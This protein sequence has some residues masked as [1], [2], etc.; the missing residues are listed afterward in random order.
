MAA[1]LDITDRKKAEKTVSKL[2][3]AIEQSPV[4]ILITDTLGN[5]EYGNPKIAEITGYTLDELI[6]ENS[7]IFRSGNKSEDEYKV[8]WGTISS[9]KVW[10]GEFLNKKKNGKLY[11]ENAIISPLKND[12][13]LITNYIAVKEDITAQ[14][15]IQLAL[16]ESE[17]RY[18]TL[19]KIS[20]VGIFRTNAE[21]YTTYVNETYCRISTLS[22]QEAMG[23]GWLK[24]VHKD[25]REKLQAEW[26]AASQ[27]KRNSSAEYRFL[28]NDRSVVYVIGQ[29][30]Q[31]K[32]SKG[33]IIGYVGTITDITARKKLES[34]KD[35]LVKISNAV[36]ATDNFESFSRYIFTELQKIIETSNFYIA[37]YDEKTQMMSVPFMAD[38]LDETIDSFHVENTL[39]GYVVNTKKAL[40][41][42]KE[43]I[44][45]HIKKGDIEQYGL[46]CEAWIGVPLFSNDK[47]VG[48]IVIQNY[49]GERMLNEEDSKVLEY[50]APQIS[51]ALER[52]KSIEDLK[53]A[54][55]KS[56]E[57]DR[58]K[59]AFLANMS[60]EIRTPMNGILGFTELLKEPK[61]SGEEQQEFIAVI[62]RSGARML[63]TI[64]DL[65][66]IST[67]EA[68][69]VK[70]LNSATNINNQIKEIAYFFKP[71][72][73]NKGLKLKTQTSLPFEEAVCF[74]DHE[75]LDAILMNLI[76]NAIKYSKKGTIE[77]G[78]NVKDK[79]IEF[80]VKDEGIGIP[81]ENFKSIFNRF[82][83]VDNTLSSDYEGS[84]LGL[85]IVKAFL[86]LMGGEIWVESIVGEG[87]KFYFTIPVDLSTKQKPEIKIIDEG[88]PEIDKLKK[89]KILVVEDDEMSE[90][91]FKITLKS[92]A[93]EIFIANTGL[94]AVEVCRNNTDLDLILMDIKMP[95][96]NGY[97][98]TKEI[99]SFNKEVIIIAQTAYAMDGDREKAIEVGCNDH[100]SKPINNQ[101][102]LELIDHYF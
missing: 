9:G 2:S 98:A 72:A 47:V 60:H 45:E 84:G 88:F 5:I 102:L 52:K 76:K 87:S 96:M 34:T 95:V 49:E 63:N 83:Q 75:K 4:S 37:L 101:K 18:H 92:I 13:G 42:K 79:H 8:L 41:I 29:T 53:L 27:S 61:L 35:L 3:L 58:L 24:A 6:G 74:T 65:I 46:L 64:K 94:E 20:P 67:I 73:D 51:V 44:S 68:G 71:E 50:I 12:K 19:A 90:M 33:E 26:I 59:S 10:K 54:L 36:L 22:P 32:N 1:V 14:K 38:Q 69:Q 15:Q 56:Q 57:S 93:P 23:N 11:W 66:D 86:E 70:V 17:L 85:S 21:G 25:D 89:L 78:Y 77:F 62:E 28:R 91:L 43:E 97:E 80:F 82:V 81:K 40:F 99:R 39:T 48:A 100:I 7:R 16:K 55:E 31:E 30:V